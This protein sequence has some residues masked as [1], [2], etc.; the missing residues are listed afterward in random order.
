MTSQPKHLHLDD[1]IFD[2]RFIHELPDDPDVSNKRRQVYGACYSRVLPTPVAN[3]SLVAYSREVAD[4]LDLTR[5]ACGSEV[6]T[7]I[8]AGN[9][10]AKGM[11]PYAT[12]YGGH[13]F[14]QWAGQLGDGR[15]IN[16]G[17]VINSEGQ[18]W[19]LQLKGAGATPYSRSADGLA[20]LRSSVREFLCSEAM[21]HLGVPTTRA[22][23]CVIT[24]EQVIRDMF[25]NG[26]PKAE[27]GAVV[28]RVA[29]S[30]TRFGHFQILTARDE[31]DNLRK[32]VDYTIRTDFP[33]LGEPTPAVY[34]TWFEEVCR[35]TAE[36]IVHWQRVGFVHGVMNTDNMSILGLTIDYGPYG[37]L[38]NYDPEWTPNTTDAG[39]RRYRYGNQP[40]IA[41]WNLAQL[42][43]ALYP[44]IKKA[45]P[46]RKAMDQYTETYIQGWQAAMAAKLGLK[47]YNPATDEALC[48]E[49]LEI[50]PLVET[51]M[52][53][54]FRQLA[55]VNISDSNASA[56]LLAEP[57]EEAYYVPQQRT[58]DYN[59]RLDIWLR[60]YIQ[61]LQQEKSDDEQRRVTMNSVNP[62]YVLRN[63]LAQLAIDM[64]EQGDYSMV[65]ELLEVLRHP[66]TE[67]PGKASF[68]AKRPDWA[69]ERAGCSMLSCSS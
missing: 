6:F 21:Y 61:R 52:T 7:Q 2:N 24:G 28:C 17:E 46:L 63:Y 14:G 25:Y 37:W 13:Q 22:L 48:T 55:M 47:S 51:D 33:H 42:G 27:P 3:P 29:P 69:R 50:L 41:F 68:A 1:L 4:F 15:A 36:M 57:L 44:L 23:S 19:A 58:T 40:A 30:F 8:M 34:I 59:G 49:L 54:F 11:E 32:L 38:E 20:V 64:A 45:E 26:N 39:E 12:C 62:R 66:Y 67:Q 43:N 31:L 56:T 18:R 60:R 5:E 53:V 10:L 16:L 35:K 9:R 65:D